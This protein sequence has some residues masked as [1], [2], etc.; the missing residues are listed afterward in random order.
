MMKQLREKRG[1]S[2]RDLAELSGVPLK[3]IQAYEQGARDIMKMQIN[4]AYRLA[5]VLGVSMNDLLH[6]F[7]D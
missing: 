5:K 6:E 3:T 4:I 1:L 7:M 2:Q